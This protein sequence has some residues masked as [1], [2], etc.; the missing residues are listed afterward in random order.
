MSLKYLLIICNFF[1]GAIQKLSIE[2]ESKLGTCL[3]QNRSKLKWSS[4]FGFSIKWFGLVLKMVEP[5]WLVWFVSTRAT[6]NE[7]TFTFVFWHYVVFFLFFVRSFYVSFLLLLLLLFSA[8]SFLFEK[9]IYVLFL[10]ISEGAIGLCYSICLSE[11]ISTVCIELF[12]LCFLGMIHLWQ[13][14]YH[15]SYYQFWELDR[16]WIYCFAID[17][18]LAVD[19]VIHHLRSWC[20]DFSICLFVRSLPKLSI[21]LYL[22]EHMVKRLV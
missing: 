14:F 1:F 3:S 11:W 8:L 21:Q 17:D 5:D 6:P 7:I 16:V 13:I 22:P 12:Y 10:A 18:M 2:Y 20:F 4:L 15:C 19:S 9:L